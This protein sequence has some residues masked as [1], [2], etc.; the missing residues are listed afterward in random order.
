M[1]KTV[2]VRF[3]PSPTG[4][5]HIGGVRTA[6]FNWLFARHNG[7][8]FILRLEDTDL[9][10]ST[11][12]AIGWILD[13]MTWLG[14]DWDEGPFRQTERF[15]IYQEHIEKLLSDGKA[16]PCYCTPDELEQRRN[17][18]MSKGLDAKYDGRCRKLSSGER[19][20]D[21][22]I[23][24]KTP[25]AGDIIVD[26]LI[27]GTVTFEESQMDDLIIKRS[28]GTPTYNLTVV[29]DDALMEVTHVIRGEDHLSNT[30][31]QI[32]IYEALGFEPPAFGHLPM[33]LGPDR[34]RLS[35]RHGAVSVTAYR[36]EGFLPQ[37]MINYLARLGWSH[38]DQEI[39]T[40][41]EMVEKFSLEKVNKS[42]AIFDTEK[43][44]WLNA[45][46]LKSLPAGEIAELLV[47]HLRERLGPEQ[48]LPIDDPRWKAWLEKAIITLQERSR[49]LREMAEM[50]AF[51]FTD[52]GDYE[53]GVAEKF[54]TP[55]AAPLLEKVAG[56]LAE[57]ED[58]THEAL[59]E[60]IK[61]FLDG[62]G[63]KLKALGQPLRIALTKRKASPGIFEVMEILG[64]E[65]VLNRIQ[66]AIDRIESY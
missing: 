38:G 47:P 58:F 62:E 33:I 36:D 23:R 13:G 60:S 55:G 59:H 52:E 19:T 39:F 22:T 6:L 48:A 51:Y 7:G 65:E 10:R 64:K 37:A 50:A 26:D 1:N 3:A 31:R 27:R 20:G 17:E 53:E 16:Y 40:R 61:A 32:Q 29:V 9:E 15:D 25:R 35:K 30:P 66:K 45:H 54:L 42:A 63:L 24:F 49:T 56:L 46:H 18:A 11:D 21:H 44:L 4:F 8:T 14:L 5:L 34:S 12:E 41:E 2:R 43:L 57:A 28:D